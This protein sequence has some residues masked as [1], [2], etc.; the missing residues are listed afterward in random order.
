[1]GDPPARNVDGDEPSIDAMEHGVVAAGLTP[2]RACKYLLAMT[3]P[4]AGLISLSLPGIFA[5]AGVLYAF[6][7]VPLVEFLLDADPIN[8][9]KAQEEIVSRDC[10][11]DGIILS[12]VPFQYFVVWQ[13]LTLVS[14]EYD[15]CTTSQ[16][17]GMTLSVGVCCGALGINAAHELCHRSDNL[18][19]IA[20]KLLLLTSMYCHFFVEHKFGHHRRVATPEDPATARRNENLYAFWARSLIGGWL[21]AFEIERGRL[22]TV[23]GSVY[24][25]ANDVLVWQVTQWSA[26]CASAW[27]FGPKAAILWFLAALVGALLLETVNYIEHYGLVRGK[28]DQG[29]YLPIEGCHSWNSNHPFSRM[30]LFELSRHSDHHHY[31]TRPYQTLR[32]VEGAL[33][34]PTGYSGM[35]LLALFPPLFFRVMEPLLNKAAGQ[36]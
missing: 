20:S 11:Y 36:A 27:Y 24:S 10:V 25:F 1:M 32:H 6:L 2:Y 26:L 29:E 15:A 28:T 22:A 23:G 4:I 16:L 31:S 9:S 8:L 14:T 3:V 7:F 35:V 30:I 34:L 21:H 17:I 19:Q 33:Q 13:F 18:S 5:W 12:M